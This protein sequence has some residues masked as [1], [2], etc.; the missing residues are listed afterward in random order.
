MLHWK[1]CEKGVWSEAIRYMSIN[2]RE[3]RVGNLQ[4][5]VNF[6]IQTDEALEHKKPDLA[7]ADKAFVTALLG[8]L[9]AFPLYSLSPIEW[10]W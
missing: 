4:N 6:P 9:F 8:T 5:L 3:G 1:A 2:H 10:I 7:V